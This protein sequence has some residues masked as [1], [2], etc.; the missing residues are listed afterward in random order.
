VEY[1]RAEPVALSFV[2]KASMRPP[3]NVVWKAPRVVGK[4]VEVVLPD[5]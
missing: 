2:A 1:R 4:L 5:T 3:P